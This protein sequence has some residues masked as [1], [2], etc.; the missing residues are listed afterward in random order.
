MDVIVLGCGVSGLTCGIRLLEEGFSVRIVSHELPPNTVSNTAAAI[1]YPYKAYPEDRV[2]GWGK[3]AYQK[4]DQLSNMD[5]S[6]VYFVEMIEMFNEQVG[7]PWWKDA[8]RRFRHAEPDELPQG[9][10]DGYLIEVP[11]IETPIYMQFLLDEYQRLGGVIEVVAEKIDSIRDLTARAE[12]VVNCAGIGAKHLCRD[13]AVFPI[14]GQIIRSSNPNIKRSFVCETGPLAFSY[15]VARNNDCILGGTA[16]EGNWDE[17]VD[18]NTAVSILEKCAEVYAV[19]ANAT[20]YEHKVGLRPGRKE[21]RLEAEFDEPAGTWV[22]HN[23][24]HGGAGFTLS[25]G[26]A[27]EVVSLAKQMALVL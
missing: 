23:Y 21:V 12:L 24:G 15:V 18:E 9:Y 17:E 13:E 16:Q 4:F 6:G 7:E 19:L 26:C 20:I 25:W 10:V 5:L 2:L 8:V 14:R 27:E 11:L 1:W 3:V 22:I